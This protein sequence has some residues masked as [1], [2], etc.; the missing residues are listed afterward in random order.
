MTFSEPLPISCPP[1]DAVDEEL[2]GFF[3]LI[4]GDVPKED[5]FFSHAKLAQIPMPKGM[6]EC[7]WC[8]CSLISKK[9]ALTL[10]KNKR[11][12]HKTPLEVKVKKGFGQWKGGDDHVDFWRYSSVQYQDLVA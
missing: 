9:K 5:D 3:R 4:E 7:R 12:R 8:S 6:D 1:A 2:K 11:H 10:L